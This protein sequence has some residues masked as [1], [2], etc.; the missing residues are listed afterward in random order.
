MSSAFSIALSSLQAQSD[1]INITGNNLANINTVGFKTSS[2]DFLDLVS[3]SLASGTGANYGMGVQTPLNT[4]EFTQGALETSTSPLA[5]AIQGNGFFVTTDPSSG[6]QLFTRDGDFAMSADGVLQT[7]TGQN[8]QGWT[9]TAAGLNTTTVPGNIQL[10][11][12]SVLPPVATQNFSFTANLNALGTAAAGTN[13]FTSTMQVID[14]LGATHNLSINFTQS[15]TANTWNYTVSIDGGDVTGGTAGTPVSLATGSVTFNSS[16][17]LQSVTPSGGAAGTAPVSVAIPP[18]GTTYT[19]AD[20]AANMSMNWNLFSNGSG[21]ITQYGEAS[22]PGTSTQDGAQSSQLSQF[23]INS[24]GQVVAQFSNGQTK[25]EAQLALATII[26][27]ETLANAGSNNFQATGNTSTPTIG[28]PQ[29]GG[30]GQIVGSSLESS[31]VDL[32][33]EFTNLIVYQRG[34]QA[35]SRVI[36]TADNMSQDLMNLIH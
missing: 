17:I 13:T 20:G 4:T 2:S 27:P 10:P 28:M 15:G 34:Y 32:A 12:G 7:Q 6:Q 18:A 30:R 23:S 22:A 16:G 19:L 26:N 11:V 9:A 25:V 29:T 31:N 24:G 33:G 35:S 21:Q 14:S 3:Q 36:T 5:A 1:A 8:V